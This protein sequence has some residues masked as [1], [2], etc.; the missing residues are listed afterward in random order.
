MAAAWFVDGAY[1]FKA[2]QS[3]KITDKLDFL[4]LRKLL[5]STYLNVNGG[6][7]I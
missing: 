5:E 4:K 6:E 3:L 1:A 2:W 7:T